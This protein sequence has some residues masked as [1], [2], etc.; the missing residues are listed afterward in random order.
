MSRVPS[1]LIFAVGTAT[2]VCAQATAAPPVLIAP[3][4]YDNR[5]QAAKTPGDVEH[6]IPQVEVTIQATPQKDFALWHVHLQTDAES[7]YEQTWAMQSHTEH[8][9]S[10]SL[11]P[12]FQFKQTSTPTAAS[13]DAQGW[14]SLEACALRGEFG[15]TRIR[16]M[17]EGEPCVAASMN[18]GA[19]RALL[20]V[21]IEREGSRLQLDFNLGGHRTRIDMNRRD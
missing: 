2:M 19:R 9:G 10:T 3:G 16:A 15:K 1:I 8:D 20:P 12:Y 14:L 11:I 13:F 5:A 4:R 21:G 18:V 7:T 17:S 6:A